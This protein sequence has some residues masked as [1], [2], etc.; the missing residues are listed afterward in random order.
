[1]ALRLILLLLQLAVS[2]WPASAATELAL[3]GC[4]THCGN[5]SIP[6][7]FGTTPECY[8]NEEFFISC[9][10]TGHAFLTD[11]RIE[12]L[13]ISVSGDLRVLSWV[14]RDCYNESGRGVGGNDPWMALAK[15]PISYTRN[16]F[17][18][19][20]CDTYAFLEGSLGKRY[21]TGCLSLCESI[22]GVTDGSCSGIGCC[23]T[24]IPANVRSINISLNSYDN[25]VG[26]WDFNPCGFAF[27]A[28][29]GTYNFS[30]TD[31]QDL[32]N[33]TRVPT[34][35]D[36]SIGDEDCEKAKDNVTSYACKEN[37]YC[38]NSDNG[39]GYRC[40]C[41]NGY[42][43]NPYLSHGCKGNVS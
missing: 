1:M 13:S 32:R 39:P 40:N 28:E 8:L 3:P 12:V 11:S 35:L 9:N 19:V 7:P 29:D 41:S 21:K 24:T 25:Y 18:T 26:V 36:W 14:A 4:A 42:E 33:I 2:L 27:V 22:G 6:Y 38:Y 10:S 43:G 23:Q 20:G 5:M 34:V 30:S 37:S 31:L 16:K 15:F 17:M